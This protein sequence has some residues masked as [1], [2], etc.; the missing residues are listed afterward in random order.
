MTLRFNHL[1]PLLT[2]FLLAIFLSTSTNAITKLPSLEDHPL[3]IAKQT[4]PLSQTTREFLQQRDN[5]T[6]KIWVFFTDKGVFNDADFAVQASRIYL[7]KKVLKRRHK[8]NKDKVVFADLPVVDSYVKA[9]EKMGGKLRRVSKWLNAASYEIP[10]DL[11]DKVSNL[12]FVASIKP[13]AGFKD[14]SLTFDN[15]PTDKTQVSKATAGGLHYGLSQTQLNQINVPAMHNKGYDGSGVTLAMFDTGFRKSHEVFAEHFAEGRVLAE[16][17]FVFNDSNTANEA[18]DVSSAWNH[19][20]Y[21]WS[22][23]AGFK[24][25]TLYGPAYKA[26]YL[27]AKTEDVRSE[28]PVEED[29]WVAALEWADSLGADV[30][31]SSLAYSDWYTYSDFDG[32]TATIT[33][34]ANTAA[35]LG[36][37]VCN[38]MGNEGPSS[39]T[40]DAPADAFNILAVG[41][42]AADGTIAGFSSR[43]PTYDGRIKPEVCA[44]GISTSCAY[45]TTDHSY[46]TA[47]GTS[48]STPLVAGAT[49]L[50]IQARPTFTPEEIRAALMSTA[51]NANSPNNDYGWGIID[52]NAALQWGADFDAD[53]KTGD[54]PLNVQFTDNSQLTPTSWKWSFGDGDSS[55]AQNPSHFYAQ[56]GAYDVSLTIESNAGEITRVKK[57]FILAFGDTLTF[58]SDSAFA[59]HQVVMSVNLINSEDLNIID[60]PFTFSDAPEIKFDSASFGSRTTYFDEIKPVLWDPWGHRYAYRLTADTGSGAT[61]LS[62]GS[63]EIM[64]LYFTIDSLELGGTTYNIDT[65]SSPYPLE[66]TSPYTTYTPHLFIGSIST[67]HVLRGDLDNNQKLN[68][69]DLLYMINY[70]FDN[71]TPPLTIQ[72]MD[73]NADLT[74]NIEDI[75]YLIN[76]MFKGGPP[77]VT[78]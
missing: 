5:K 29:N 60:I 51:S 19:G 45:A 39:G 50:L 70:S 44:M 2:F 6:A 52:V 25:S 59:G 37:V 48:L 73:V 26:Y 22:T 15:I 78:P 38:A 54:A 31:S 68:T 21:T 17:D 13:V 1:K 35:G 67:I 46:G 72:S 30:I 7:S 57:G 53:I 42:V 24:D 43:G 32:N 71:G 40:L 64:K 8:V 49:C 18:E 16:Y 11:L 58:A 66:L 23:A 41:A 34:A 69:N 14:P 77:P 9:V 65:L 47:S 74:L 63:G 28:T 27:L 4:F 76:F 12:P 36:I 3:V 10:L 61:P 33:I 75:N 62:P 20:T 55:F 56:A